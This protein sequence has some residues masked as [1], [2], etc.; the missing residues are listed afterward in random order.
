M[1]ITL[2]NDDEGIA[3]DIAWERATCAVAR[4]AALLDTREPG[5]ERRVDPARLHMADGY[6]CIL[7]QL[8]GDYN[9]GIHA[10]GIFSGTG[11]HHAEPQDNEQA[12]ACD[13]GFLADEDWDEDRD[14][15]AGVEPLGD[16]PFTYADLNAA[17]LTLLLARRAEAA[18]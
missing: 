4:G 14:Y 10:I 5:W 6:Y 15:Y 13:F 3:I 9:V 11:R 2:R 8:F 12:A 7:G 18:G 1:T 16:Q 17:W